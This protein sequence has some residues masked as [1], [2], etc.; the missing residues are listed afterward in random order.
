MTMTDILLTPSEEVGQ[1]QVM[2]MKRYW[3]KCMLQ[4][5]GVLK[6]DAFGEEFQLDKTM[7][8][9]LGLGLE[10]TV[11]Y[12]YPTGPSFEEFEQWVVEVNGRPLPENITRFNNSILNPDSP[13][14]QSIPKV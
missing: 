13:V 1:L 2:H 10:Q 6:P 7:L 14:G 4:R 12:L 11:K 5:S 9:V 8:S 3:H